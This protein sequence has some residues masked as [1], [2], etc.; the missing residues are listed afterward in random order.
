M[1]NNPS[2]AVH[3]QVMSLRQSSKPGQQQLHQGRK[4][5]NTDCIQPKLRAIEHVST[6][7][8]LQMKS[9]IP[10]LDIK[11]LQQSEFLLRSRQ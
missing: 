1:P 5:K 3:E 11:D 7:N 9:V 10:P 6:K 2:T 4:N 8:K